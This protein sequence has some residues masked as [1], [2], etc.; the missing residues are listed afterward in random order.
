MYKH[1]SCNKTRW[2]PLA[3]YSYFLGNLQF[4]LEHGT[5]YEAICGFHPISSKF[6]VKWRRNPDRD[7]SLIE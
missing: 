6:D 7:G 3:H 5:I 2:I 4:Y 1:P